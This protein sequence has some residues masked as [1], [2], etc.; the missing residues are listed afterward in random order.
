MRI[1][2]QIESYDIRSMSSIVDSVSSILRMCCVLHEAATILG[3]NLTRAQEYF[4][5]FNM[6]QAIEVID[7]YNAKLTNAETE[8]NEL[9]K[10]VNEYTEKLNHAWRAW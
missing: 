2:D 5:S 1:N 9:L 8:L 3:G 6:E 4:T 7:R 10:S